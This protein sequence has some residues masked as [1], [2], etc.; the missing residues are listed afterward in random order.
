MWQKT[1]ARRP[2]YL[3]QLPETPFF[4][5]IPQ[6]TTSITTL[7]N[8]KIPLIG[9]ST[10]ENKTR[11]K[12]PWQPSLFK[13]NPSVFWQT[14]RYTWTY[15]HISKPDGFIEFPGPEPGKQSPIWACFHSKYIPLL[16]GITPFASP[17]S[18]PCRKI[19]EQWHSSGNQPRHP[20]IRPEVIPERKLFSICSPRL[21]QKHQKPGPH[22]SRDSSPVKDSTNNFHPA[23]RVPYPH[24]YRHI[25]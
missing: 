22:K 19:S 6:K 24:E 18:P 7:F 13:P 5:A 10:V 9:L 25:R 23:N 15:F 20:N 8:A 3:S 2:V 16:D 21:R 4:S 12:G 14:E 17:P 1:P 11:N